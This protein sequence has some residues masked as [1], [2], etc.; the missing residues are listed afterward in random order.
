M[1]SH[2]ARPNVRFIKSDFLELTK[3]YNFNLNLNFQT[4]KWKTELKKGTHT[5]QQ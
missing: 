5:P 4:K 2:L 3:V 1:G